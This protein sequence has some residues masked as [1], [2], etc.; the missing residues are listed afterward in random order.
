[1]AGKSASR[2]LCPRDYP[3]GSAKL[4]RLLEGAGRD[5]SAVVSSASKEDRLSA[6]A[7]GHRLR[8]GARA[9]SSP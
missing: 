2:L 1:M 9:R 5:G 4:S 7:S 6:R 3:I 8:L